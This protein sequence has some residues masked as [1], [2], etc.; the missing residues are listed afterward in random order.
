MSY[1][2]LGKGFDRFN[3]ANETCPTILYSNFADGIFS[4]CKNTFFFISVLQFAV[5]ALMY[6]N[7]GKGKYWRI[8]FYGA[9]AGFMGS[10]LESGTIAFICRK[11]TEDKPY[12]K[13]I[14][15]FIAE[16]FWITNEYSIPFLNLIKMKAFAKGKAAKAVNYVV[17]GIF[18]LFAF[19]RFWIGYVRSR[20]GVIKNDDIDN[21]HGLAFA[22]MAIADLVCTISILYFVRKHNKQEFIKTS[23]ITHYIKHSSYTILICVDIASVI[24]AITCFLT[25]YT[26]VPKSS[27]LPLH[28]L[29]CSFLLILASDA[30]LFKYEANASSLQNSST[31]YVYDSFSKSNNYSIDHNSS[32]NHSYKRNLS[33][34]AFSMNENGNSTLYSKSSFKN[35][36][37]SAVSAPVI[38]NVDSDIFP[39]PPPS[40]KH[41]K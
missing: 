31:K 16:F 17:L 19:C 25:T 26:K 9:F 13:I 22:C 39:Q 36:P 15:L 21:S 35:Y 40:I 11:G 24:L 29:K 8:L 10:V 2:V 1:Y 14:T 7:V 41:L 34:P 18:P 30:L 38:D 27:S 6:W 20:D 33:N 5:V 37:K 12:T 32:S 3:P 23:N 4:R 28:C